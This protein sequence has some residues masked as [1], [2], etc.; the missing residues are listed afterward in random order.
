MMSKQPPR[1]P[2][3]RPPVAAGRG[4]AAPPPA[5]S[6]PR[7]P[8]RPPTGQDLVGKPAPDFTLQGS[9]GNNH[10]LSALK[11]S[12]VTL[13]FLAVWCPHCQHDAPE[14]NVIHDTYQGKNVQFLGVLANPF[15]KNYENS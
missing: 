15:G 4:P 6:P 13:E 2:P 10:T 12:V 1:K 5:P 11:G 14:M 3:A 8:A 7:P 9:D